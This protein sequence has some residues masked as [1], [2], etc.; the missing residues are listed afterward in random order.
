MIDN[1]IETMPQHIK[2]RIAELTRQKIM[3]EDQIEHSNSFTK[4]SM[5]EQDLYDIIHSIM[6]LTQ[7]YT[8]ENN[9]R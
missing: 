5:L 8:G 4:R 1:K 9:V 3:L 7:P 2:Q 6:L